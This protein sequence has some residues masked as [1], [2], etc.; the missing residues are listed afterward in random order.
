MYEDQTD[1]WVGRQYGPY[2]ITGVLGRG[3]VA[4]CYRATTLRGDEVGLKVLTPFAEARAEVR[5]LF[6]QEYELMA[7]LDHPNV[8]AVHGA[9]VI[10]GAHYIE[11][12]IVEGETLADRCAS[13]HPPSLAEGIAAIQQICAAL[14]H[15]HERRIVHRDVK[16]SNIMLDP[17]PEG[18]DRAVLF[19]FGLAHDL[20]G[21]PSPPGRVYGS[22][23]YLSPEQALANPVDA[24]TDIYGLG[25][26]LYVLTVGS[27][28]FYG[29]RND[30][31][32]AHVRFPPPDPAERG[33]S[34]E[35]SEI[36][37]TAMAKAPDDRFAGGAD[38]AAALAALEIPAHESERRRGFLRRLR[39]RAQS[40]APAERPGTKHSAG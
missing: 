13:R 11:M 10:G 3:T 29:E 8:L 9:G 26:T 6:E 32:H 14:D 38:L 20:D 39:D 35:L 40:T 31:L 36:I 28:P 16:P 30:L 2:K 34:P 4:H 18:G 7:R 19:D 25:S 5:S 23:M 27:A 21:P 24:R 15:V 12:E 17:Q 37:L 1:V 33:V 22:P